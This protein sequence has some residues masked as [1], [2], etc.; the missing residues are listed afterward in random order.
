VVSQKPQS[1]HLSDETG[2][3]PMAAQEDRGTDVAT[4]AVVAVQATVR[5]RIPQ[6][7]EHWPQAP[8]VYAYC[9]QGCVLQATLPAGGE[10]GQELASATLPSAVSRHCTGRKAV[11]PPHVEEQA[12]HCPTVQRPG[13]AQAWV[14]HGMVSAMGVAEQR[15]SGTGPVTL[16]SH[17]AV[18]DWLPPPHEKEQAP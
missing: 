15:D 17:V 4:P 9:V 5:L 3:G 12:P 11:P 7:A 13:V 6:G 18:R 16:L 14:L 2:A 8:T 1:V 10:A